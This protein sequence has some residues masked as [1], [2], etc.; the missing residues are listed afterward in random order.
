MDNRINIPIVTLSTESM[1]FKKLNAPDIARQLFDQAAGILTQEGGVE[2]IVFLIT[3]RVC[4]L[5]GANQFFKSTETKDMLSFLLRKTAKDEDILGVALVI[6]GWSRAATKEEQQTGVT[7]TS[8]RVCD[9][10]DRKEIIVVQCEWFDGNRC[11]LSATYNRNVEPTGIEAITVH[12][13]TYSSEFEGRFANIFPPSRSG[14]Y[15]H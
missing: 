10:V 4:Y 5:I 14:G 2:P 15:V 8:Q 13:P 11:M 1:G 7:D 9:H 6:D 3:S 12:K